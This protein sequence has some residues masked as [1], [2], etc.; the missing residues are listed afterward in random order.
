M[1]DQEEAAFADHLEGRRGA[2]LIPDQQMVNMLE[3][4]LQAMPG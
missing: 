1:K 3:H 4:G 2:C